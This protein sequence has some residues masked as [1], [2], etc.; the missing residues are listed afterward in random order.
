[1]IDDSR[2]LPEHKLYEQ[3]GIYV[4]VSTTSVA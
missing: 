1:M 2:P 3:T 4:D